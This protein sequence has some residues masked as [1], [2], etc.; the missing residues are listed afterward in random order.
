M[1]TVT[2]T[3]GH[4]GRLIVRALLDRGVPAS[5]IRAL[6]RTP[7]RAADLTDLGVE[8]RPADY[9]RPETL[10]AALDGTDRL[11]LVSSSEV[12]QRLP[13][14]RNVID[15]AVAA[16]VGLLAY[17]S[18]LNAD[19]S[20]AALAEEHRATEE[21]IRASGL[22]YTFLRN[23]WYLENYTENLGPVLQ[24]GTLNGSA[25]DGRVAAASRADYAGA[26]A[27]VLTADDP[28]G[29]VYELGGDIPF[30]L[31]ELAAE[32]SRQAGTPI[33]YTDLP[34]PEYTALLVAAGVPEAFAEMLADSDLAIARGDLATTRRDLH[35]LLGRPSTPPAAAV[36]AALA[37]R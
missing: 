13:Q 35:D 7:E 29:T 10:P 2:G 21:A 22:P 15:A 1:I 11:L 23:G 17:T 25:G 24:F 3:S 27:A 34:A 4:L 16:G 12:G 30:T 32:V 20:K 5:G 14:H 18:I 28:A 9:S 26:A 37:E 19:S 33:D 31:A 6:A 36:A 8:V